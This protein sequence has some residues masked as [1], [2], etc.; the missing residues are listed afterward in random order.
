MEKEFVS[1]EQALELKELGFDEECLARQDFP[2]EQNG[3]FLIGHSSDD[4]FL[5]KQS[6]FHALIPLYQQA[7]RWFREKYKMCHWVYQSNDESYFYS[8]LKQ[9]RYLVTNS[10]EYKTY[11]ETELK[12]LKK[13]IEIVKNEKV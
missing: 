8:I 5:L 9:G 12:C 11:E 10:S 1:Y 2:I 4:E 3:Y 13:L 7:F 6:Q